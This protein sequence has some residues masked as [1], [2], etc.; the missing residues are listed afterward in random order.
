LSYV[1]GQKSDWRPCG[2]K[3]PGLQ[4]NLCGKRGVN[5]E[6]RRR[7]NRSKN[8][9]SLIFG[10]VAVALLSLYGLRNAFVSSVALEQQARC[11]MEEHLHGIHCSTEDGRV[12]IEP[13]HVHNRNCYLV[14]LKDNN[15]NHL[16]GMVD[17]DGSNNLETLIRKTVST[18]LKYNKDLITLS[19]RQSAKAETLNLSAAAW[20]DTPAEEFSG[21][22]EVDTVALNKTMEEHNIEPRIVFNEELYNAVELEEGPTDTVLTSAV[23][24]SSAAQNGSAGDVSLLALGANP[25]NTRGNANIYVYLDNN[26]ECV[27]TTTITGTRV[28]SRNYTATISTSNT[29]RL[30]NDSLGTNLAVGSFGVRCAEVNDSNWKNGTVTNN[31]ITIG[32]NYTSENNAR[33]AKNVRISDT[34][35]NPLPFYT[36]TFR[37]QNGTTETRYARGGTTVALPAG[38]DWED[39]DGNRYGGGSNIAITKTTMF[40]ERNP[41]GSIRIN[42]NVAFPTV[43]DVATTV[44]TKPTLQGT[45]VQ[46][47]TD[48]ISNGTA[49]LVRNVSQ[50]EV[51][52]KVNNHNAGMSRVVRFS[53]WRVNGGDT[54]ISANASLTWEELQAYAVNGQINLVAI[55]EYRAVQTAS[56]YIRYDSVAMD[57]T[58]N[59]IEGVF[60]DYT[61]ELFATFV[62]GADA[63]TMNYTQLNNKY[64]IADVSSD[65]SYTADK[66]IRARYGEQEGIWLQSFPKDEDVFE[67]LKAYADHLQ[68]DGKAVDVNDLNPNAYTIRWY[69]MKCQSDAWHIDGRLVKKEGILNVTKTFAGN[70][71]GVDL[72]KE[73]FRITAVNQDGDKRH[74]L[75]LRSSS[76]SEYDAA[77]D[78]YT[79]EIT[80]V[81]YGE[82]W[83]ITE[84]TYG[85]E[86]DQE[87]T[88]DS[89]ASYNVVDVFNVANN[90]V[91]HD[92]DGD[93]ELAV[94]V[95]GQ[96]YATD[97][98]DVQVLRVDFTNIYHS[99][100]SIIIKKEDAKTGNALGGATFQLLQNGEVMRFT[101][102]S[103]SNRYHYDPSGPIVELS[104]SRSGYYEIMTTGFSYDDGNI[105]VEELQ[106][107]VGYTPIEKIV[108]GKR[109]NGTIEILSNSPRAS[110]HNGLLIVENS[111]ENTSVTAVKEWLCPE[112]EWRDVTVQ[113]LA[114]GNLASALIPGVNATAQLTESGGWTY[115][116]ENLPTHANGTEIVWSLRETKIGSES[117]KPDFTFANWLVF[118]G[119]PV[120]TRDDDGKVTNY[121]ITIQNET[122]RTLLRLTKMDFVDRRQLSG[123]T[124]VLQRLIPGGGSYIEDPEF[125]VRTMTTDSGGSLTFDN[126]LYGRYR[127]T[128]TEQPEGYELMDEPI[129]L[130]INEDG[131]VSVES[132]DYAEAGSTAYSVL[133]YNRKP[134]PLPNTGGGGSQWYHATGI[135]LMLAAACGYILP[136]EKN[137]RKGRYLPE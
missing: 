111:T 91:G 53:G 125:V 29:L 46:T 33:N 103:D 137:R 28:G 119:S 23:L 121:R 135:L 7:K 117:C 76:Y 102:D 2:C 17:D 16:L 35:G 127:L 43:T 113:L 41:D 60:T 84:F 42:Y 24:L 129:Y 39:Q 61:P 128:E 13:E 133:V 123:A 92:S 95:L 58:G 1:I 70:R 21:V 68:V 44:T 8:R 100:D 105:T 62:G 22:S 126:L 20:L 101:Y 120:L 130:T 134:L 14:L 27:G 67:Q 9:I 104:G 108:V 48:T 122:R 71:D 66:N 51:L 36:V 25:S 83:I 56:F 52:A 38:H 47:I 18:A 78:T 93:G 106:A 87:T 97:A 12:C 114:N 64:Y 115:T 55:W 31:T 10:A 34:A 118:Y 77:T 63:Q 74:T 90:K 85:M 132:H 75:T 69:V 79:W 6:V 131:S 86:T 32:S 11:G 107:P 99:E 15:I 37:Y 98:G 116:W 57:T 3:L 136:R 124:F 73:D 54:V 81:E 19:S 40:T 94:N 26:W 82:P 50:Q 110:Y 45:A 109:S 88:Y 72:A 80:G 30:V 112:A 59:Q 5:S 49:A 4:T 89:Y 65:N 96:T